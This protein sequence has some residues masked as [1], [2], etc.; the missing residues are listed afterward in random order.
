MK[1]LVFTVRDSKAEVFLAPFFM[2]T[3]GMAIRGFTAMVNDRAHEMCQFAEDYTLFFLGHY[4][5]GTGMME[6][7]ASPESMGNAVVFQKEEEL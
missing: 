3:K 4:D 7:L 1:Q 6:P 2:R 5:E